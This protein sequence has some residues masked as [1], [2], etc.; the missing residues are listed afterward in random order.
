[1]NK[2]L[3]VGNLSS[4]VD[5]AALEHLFGH[6]GSV[7]SVRVMR[8]KETGCARGFAFVEMA[9]ELDAQ[10]AVRQFHEYQMEGRVLTVNEARSKAERAPRW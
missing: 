8:D 3:L 2:S 5:E 9:T 10:R 1:M 7:E 6:A 4:E